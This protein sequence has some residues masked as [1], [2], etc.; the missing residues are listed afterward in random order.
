MMINRLML[1]CLILLLHGYGAGAATGPGYQFV[2]KRMGITLYERWVTYH[3]NKVRQ[4]KAVFQV[5]QVDAGQV[6][7]LLKNQQL[8]RIWN[9]S[10]AKVVIRP[11]VQPQHWYSYIRYKL[12]WPMN[13]QEDC[14]LYQSRFNPSAAHICKV[15]FKSSTHPDFP[16]QK[17]VTRI[18]GT[19]GSWLAEQLPANQL[20]ITYQIMTDKS[21]SLPRWVT[22]PI[23]YDN[24]FHTLN[25]FKNLLDQ[26]TKNAE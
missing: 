11:G 2:E 16:K 22:D 4:L 20:Q 9:V 3:G 23:V 21:A 26:S 1:I 5:S 10:A 25:S 19:L 14:L 8:A 6:L 13:D 12:P 7:P 24:L 18:T 17:N 15:D